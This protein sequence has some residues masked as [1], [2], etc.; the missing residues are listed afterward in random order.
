MFVQ[1]KKNIIFNISNKNPSETI[2]K[3]YTIN[4]HILRY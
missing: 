2:L 1:N 4:I 3:N